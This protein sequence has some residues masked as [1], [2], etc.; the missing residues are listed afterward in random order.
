MILIAHMSDPIDDVLG[1][2]IY[3]IPFILCSIS[4]SIGYLTYKANKK[5][6]SLA[7]I[8]LGVLFAIV[9]VFLTNFY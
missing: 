1:D 7:L 6:L 5:K 3:F 8:V 4:F 9:G 2:F